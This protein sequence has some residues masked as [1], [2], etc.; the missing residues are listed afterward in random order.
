MEVEVIDF[1]SVSP[2]EDSFLLMCYA[3]MRGGFPIFLGVNWKEDGESKY[4]ALALVGYNI[5]EEKLI[6]D[7]EHLSLL[8]NRIQKL[9]IHDDNIG[10]FSRYKIHNDNP[11]LLNCEDRVDED[12]NLIEINPFFM[13]IPIYHKIRYPFS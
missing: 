11:I 6:V 2:T 3:Y 12:G 5:S 8:G 7:S 10:P 13:V 9:Y 4:H 1:D